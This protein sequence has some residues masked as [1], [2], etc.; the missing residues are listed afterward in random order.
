VV[1]YFVMA[2]E[3]C[4]CHGRALVLTLGE[5]KKQPMLTRL[6]TGVR[7]KLAIAMA[8][9]AAFCFALPPAA[10]AFGHGSNTPTCLSHADAVNHGIGA[11]HHAAKPTGEHKPAADHDQMSCCGLFCLSAVVADDASGSERLALGVPHLFAPAPRL[12]SRA[13]ILPERPPNALLSA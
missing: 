6:S 1:N 7:Y 11:N 5:S 4:G 13:P 12:I 10:L 3:P 9:L 2:C 8:V